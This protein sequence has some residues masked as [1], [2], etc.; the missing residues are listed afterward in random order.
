M[1]HA[2][3]PVIYF[4]FYSSYRQGIKQIPFKFCCC[5][6][7]RDIPNPPCGGLIELAILPQ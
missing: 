5:R 3:N 7:F 1:F 4:M 2:I 6:N